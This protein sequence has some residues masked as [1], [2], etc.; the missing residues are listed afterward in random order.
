MRNPSPLPDLLTGCLLGG[1]IGDALGAPVEGLGLDQ[2][3]ERYGGDGLTDYAEGSYGIGAVTDE[4]QLTLRVAEALVR[5][6]IRERSKGIGGAA[7][8]IVQMLCLEWLST[9]GVDMP[10]QGSHHGWPFGNT[11]MHARRGHSAAT[12]DALRR[13]AA[14]QRPGVPLGTV[15][16]PVNNSKGCAAVV[17]AAPC[18]FGTGSIDSAFGMAE[19]VA[20]LTHGHRTAH[21]A[22]GAF[23]ATVWGLVRGAPLEQALSEGRGVLEDREGHEEVSRALDK[24]VSVAARGVPTAADLAELGDGWTSEEALAVAVCVALHA[25]GPYAAEEGAQ[26]TPATD[27]RA[28]PKAGRRSLLLAVNH[29]GDSDSLGALCGNLIGARHGVHAFPGHWQ[30]QLEVRDVAIRLAADCALEY[31]PWPP[32]DSDFGGAHP[33]WSRRHSA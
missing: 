12:V 7:P 22:A 31:A 5:A 16:E 26:G 27:R 3:R 23:S 25:D 8:G 4:T 18:G 30:S 15:A 1:A 10:P 9:Q 29:S 11:A 14:R 21:L 28:L 20:A 17:R 2:I 19:R 24:A 13:A 6:S 32:D 33:S